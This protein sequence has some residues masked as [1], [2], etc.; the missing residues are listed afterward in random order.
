[1]V[2]LSVFGGFICRSLLGC[3]HCRRTVKR[4]IVSSSVA[5]NRLFIHTF[6][7]VYAYGAWLGIIPILEC[8][9]LC[10]RKLRSSYHQPAMY[11][12]VVHDFIAR[13][14]KLSRAIS[15]CLT[16]S[17][18]AFVNIGDAGWIAICR[19]AFILVVLCADLPRHCR[20]N[21]G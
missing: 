15:Q 16:Q 21:E 14:F 2:C 12:L 7:G 6:R 13:T 17:L 10:F 9:C 18:L 1:M 5:G 11:V 4:Q 3:I 8:R 19:L 20:R